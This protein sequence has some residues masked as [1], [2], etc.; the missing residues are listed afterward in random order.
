MEDT[1][2]KLINPEFDF[3]WNGE[4]FHLKKANISKVVQ[5][6]KRA[7]E[8]SLQNEAGTELQL[9]A[10]AIYLMLKEFKPDITEEDVLN[11]TPGDIEVLDLFVKLGFLNPARIKAAIQIMNQTGDKSS[12]PSSTE[13]DGLSQKSENSA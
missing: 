13:Q 12:L 4:T 8:L 6:Q 1:L 10:Y 2:Y 3:E 7:R 11:N 5:Y 9:G